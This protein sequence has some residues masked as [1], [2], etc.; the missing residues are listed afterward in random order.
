MLTKQA[1]V[2]Q[3]AP[4]EETY[5]HLFHHITVMLYTE[6]LMT[7]TGTILDQGEHQLYNVKSCKQIKLHQSDAI[8]II[9]GGDEIVLY[10][11]LL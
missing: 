9:L 10:E 8:D 2:C 6:A 11:I 7:N 1:L 3:E 4:K 5:H